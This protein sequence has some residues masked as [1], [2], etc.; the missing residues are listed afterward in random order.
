MEDVD[1]M[2]RDETMKNEQHL[3]DQ[4]ARQF[5]FRFCRR[6]SGVPVE[7]VGLGIDTCSSARVLELHHNLTSILSKTATA[8]DTVI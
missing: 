1:E 2:R 7:L 4:P 8:S 3:L 5:K 6:M